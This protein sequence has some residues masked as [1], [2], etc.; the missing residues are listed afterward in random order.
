MDKSVCSV[1]FLVLR[2][3]YLLLI[4]IKSFCQAGLFSGHST[5][6]LQRIIGIQTEE[7]LQQ[8]VRKMYS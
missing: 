5:E 8:C 2:S 4:S 1:G 6:H 7:P 3:Y